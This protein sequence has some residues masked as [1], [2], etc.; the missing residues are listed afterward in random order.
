MR[1]LVNDDTYRQARKLT[2]G[3]AG[4]LL[5]DRPE[6]SASRFRV[7][8]NMPDT[9]ASGTDKNVATVLTYTAGTMRPGLVM[10]LWRGAY[11]VRDPYSD[12]SSGRVRVTLTLLTGFKMIDANVYRR[13]EFQTA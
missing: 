9:P 2:I 3:S 10:P 6:M 4:R 11:L 7:S 8:A 5:R 12:A 1:M 13:L